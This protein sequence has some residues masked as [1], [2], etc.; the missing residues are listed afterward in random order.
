MI[1]TLFT[2][3]LSI[4][5]LVGNPMAAELETKLNFSNSYR[6]DNL[7]WNIAGDIHGNNPNVLSELTWSD[8]EIYQAGVGL[9]AVMDKGLYMRSSLGFG[10]ILDGD[11]QDSDFLGDNRTQEFSRSNNSTD[12]GDVLD[13]TVG[14]G[15][16]FELI[17]GILRFVPLVGYS[18]SEQNL[19][20]TDGFQTISTPGITPAIGPIENLDST[21]EAKRNGPWIGLDLSFGTTEKM[22]LFAGFEY[23]WATYHAEGDWNLRNDL[24]HPKSFEQDTDLTSIMISLGGEYALTGSWAINLTLNYE[25]Y[26]TDAGIDR[27]FFADGSTRDTRL[28]EINWDSFAIILGL[29][30]RFQYDLSR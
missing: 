18:H 30:Y 14:L 6:V 4:M 3:S 26:S 25:D 27:M 28:N 21:Y 12:D 10:W 13:A 11:N 17:S 22:T 1:A 19:T 16:Q 20:I 29:I 2:A 7:D 23:H 15:Y 24:D 8:L 5:G 9:K